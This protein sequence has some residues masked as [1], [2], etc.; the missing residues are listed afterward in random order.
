MSTTDLKQADLQALGHG[1]YDTIKELVDELTEV[2]NDDEYVDEETSREAILNHP[3]SVEVRDDWYSP[4][5]S[6]TDV[7][8]EYRILIAWGGPAAQITGELDQFNQPHTATLQVQD[9][10]IPWT[11]VTGCDEDILLTYAQQFYFGE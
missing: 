6:K 10:F 11:D 7:D 2:T 3:L 4:G 8:R 9:W 5:C 1:F